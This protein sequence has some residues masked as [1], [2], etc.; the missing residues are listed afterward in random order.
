M[1][2]EKT[3]RKR[4]KPAKKRE[5]MNIKQMILRSAIRQGFRMMELGI[6]AIGGALLGVR[7]SIG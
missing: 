4:K 7:Q 1:K 6:I 5:G 2:K 3:T